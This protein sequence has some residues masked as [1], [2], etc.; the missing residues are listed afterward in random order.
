MALN[1]N[2]SSNKSL[3]L[4]VRQ[5]N[6]E[7][8]RSAVTRRSLIKGSAALGAAALGAHASTTALGANS[9]VGAG[10]K[11]S[12]FPAPAFLQG[13]TLRVVGT[14]VSLL[15]P[16]KAQ[17]EQDL[18]ITLQYDVKDG[19]TAQQIAV[20]QPQSW[21]LYDQ[22]FNSVKIVWG[23]GVCQP[24]DVTRLPQWENISPLTTVGKINEEAKVGA[25]DAPVRLLYVQPDGSLLSDPTEQVSM[26]PLTHNVDAFGYQSDVVGSDDAQS[27]AIFFDPDYSGRVGLYNDPATGLMDLALGAQAAGLTTFDDIGNMTRDEIDTIMDLLIEQKQAGQFRAFWNSFDE[28]VNLMAS[29]EVVVESMWSPAVTALRTRGVPVIYASPQ[30]GY[31]GWHG[32]IM[33]N[34]QASGATLDAAYEYIDWWMNGW[35]GALVARQGYYFSIPENAREHLSE[36]EWDYWYGGQPAAEDMLAPDGGVVAPEGEVRDGGSYETRMSNIAVW[37]S[38]MD[39]HQYL[40]SKWNEFLAS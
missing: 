4:H 19:L 24:V 15:D 10:A 21:D 9:L 14:G 6:G 18:G 22:W 2:T 25:G 36:A 29:G 32:G 20:T 3:N 33:I 5:V 34:E 11:R 1:R 31:R 35:A 8:E 17:A 39:E 16:I 23:A 7:P 27:W 26:L 13:T 28:S 12:A 30:E 37:N 40:V 38:V